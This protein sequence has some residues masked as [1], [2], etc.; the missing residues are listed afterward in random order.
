MSDITRQDNYEEFTKEC[1]FF[2]CQYIYEGDWD[3]KEKFI[4][5]S[6]TPEEELL[7]KYPRIMKKLSPYMF[8]N[9][10][11]GEVYSESARNIEKYRKRSELEFALDDKEYEGLEYA[12]D[13]CADQLEIAELIEKALALCTPI[14]RER[15]I[16]HYMEGYEIAELSA[17]TCRSAVNESIQAALKKI[18]KNIA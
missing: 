1:K 13:S 17:G 3:G 12:C 9:A 11:C 6:D 2:Y 16:K 15:L 4:V 14:Q 18:R 8:C 7:K 5:A 10:E